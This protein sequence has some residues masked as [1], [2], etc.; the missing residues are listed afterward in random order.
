MSGPE[1]IRIMIAIDPIEFEIKSSTSITAL[2]NNYISESICCKYLE[3]EEEDWTSLDISISECSEIKWWTDFR[4]WIG[5][6]L[7]Q[8]I[9]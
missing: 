8:L 4:E 3:R 2:F 7:Q 5:G 6:K 1:W 9:K